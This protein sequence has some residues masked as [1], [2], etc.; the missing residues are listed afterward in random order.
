MPVGYAALID[1]YDLNVP[2]PIKLAAIGQRHKVYQVDEWN[3]YTPRHKPD[4]DLEGQPRLR[5]AL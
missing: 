2:M 4:D 1:A 5:P 3:F